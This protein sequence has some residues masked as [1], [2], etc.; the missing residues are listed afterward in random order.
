MKVTPTSRIRP[1]SPE[2]NH[3][4]EHGYALYWWSIADWYQGEMFPTETEAREAMAL[5]SAAFPDNLFK[6]FEVC[7]IASGNGDRYAYRCD[8]GLDLLYGWLRE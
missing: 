7:Q 2:H 1:V 3:K 4:G 5:E 8:L 6:V